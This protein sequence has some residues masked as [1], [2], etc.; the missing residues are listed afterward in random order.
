MDKI[1]NIGFLGAGDISLLHAE[2][3]A[4]LPTARLRGL[5]SI[6]AAQAAEKARAF[7]CQTYESAEA[8]VADPEI[9]A[10]FVLTNLETHARYATLAMDAGKAV[11]VEKPVAASVAELEALKACAE[12]NGAPLAP[13]H[14]YIHEPALQR[15]RALL[16][17]GKLGELVAVYIL[18]N[19]HHPEDVA[20][21]YPG[22]IRHIL[23]HHSY[24]LLYLAGAPE[25]VSAMKS[26]VHYAE[27][28]G[29]DLALVNLRLK[30]GALAHFCADF[31][32]DDHG[33][34]SWTFMV[35]V[36]GTK[37]SA[38]FSYGDWVENAPGPVHSHTYSAYEY[39]VREEVR[40]F[41]EDILGKGKAPLSTIDDAIACQ[42]IVEACERSADGG[43][44][45]PL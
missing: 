5:W 10:V 40:Y 44:E 26:V 37:G 4:H 39:G 25:A 45:F 18:Y 2:A 11:L 34:D 38:R 20:R 32:A 16:D 23:T 31:A 29:E 17:A 7:G 28:Q 13:G 6:D 8:L 1:T 21:R 14:N 12:K 35:K 27:F 9:D 36:L 3:I 24:I 33:G 15:T 43:R 42:K 41:V 30:N 22:V 19:I